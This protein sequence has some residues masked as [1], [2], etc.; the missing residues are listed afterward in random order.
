MEELTLHVKG[1]SPEPYELIF[2]KRRRQ[3]NGAVQLP[4]RIVQQR[5]QTP[6]IDIGRRRQCRGW[7]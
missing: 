4:C 3:L 5:L 7:R 6:V 1:S 2:V